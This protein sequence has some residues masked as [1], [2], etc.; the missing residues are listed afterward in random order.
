MLPSLLKV[1]GIALG[2]VLF[3][4][5]FVLVQALLPTQASIA[6]QGRNLGYVYSGARSQCVSLVTEG[7]NEDDLLLFGSSELSTPPSLVPEVPAVVFG[8]NA[9]G[10]QLA[11]IGEAYNQ[12]LWHAIA[13][14]AYAPSVPNRKVSIIVSPSWFFD[15]GLDNSLFKTR[16]SYPLYRQ[17]MAN[18]SISA[19]SR[20]YVYERLLQQG[21]DEV[22]IRAGAGSDPLAYVND[23]VFAAMS[24]L[25]IRNQLRSLDG[26]GL[27]PITGAAHVP[28]FE[29]WR[30]H[31]LEDAQNLSHNEWGFDDAF[32]EDNVGVYKDQIQG[33]LTGETFSQT[34]EYDDFGLFLRICQETG[35]EPLVIICPLSG[36]YYD[37]VGIDAA[38][39]RACYDHILEIA[40]AYNVAVA[41]FSDREYERYFLHDQVHFGWTGWVD[42]EEAL[43][44]FAKEN[45]HV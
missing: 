21:I 36:D 22:T 27:N 9:Y 34:P 43:Y 32:Y 30:Q 20:A 33:R 17:F 26:F 29:R 12:S 11:T 15:G 6:A 5:L 38:T 16:F 41:D 7:M 37:W 39:R 8:Q 3:I 2:L 14:G 40:N 28:N 31:A 35:L 45:D 19:E 10:F 42:V 44:T 18:S 23:T 1:R 13:A 4:G 25:H 24:D